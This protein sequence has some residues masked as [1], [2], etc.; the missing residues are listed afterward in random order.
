MLAVGAL[1]LALVIVFAWQSGIGQHS[2]TYV[3]VDLHSLVVD[4]ANPSHLFVGG[5]QG[6]ARSDDAGHSWHPLRSLDDADAMGWAFT[7][8]ATW[9]SGHPGVH[10]SA[11]GGLHF[12]GHNEGLPATDVH[13][14]G[15]NDR[16]LYAGSPVVGVMV[17]TDGAAH[18]DIRTRDTGQAFFGHILVDPA[19]PDHAVAADARAGAVETTDG[20]RHWK[21]LGGVNGADWVSW[22][23]DQ[24]SHLVVTGDGQAAAS[25]DGGRTWQAL[26]VPDG[27]SIVEAAPT[28]ASVLYAAAHRGTHARIWV[29]RDGGAHWRTP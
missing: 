9:Q 21:V 4:P 26:T 13:A 12:S 6:V 7:S 14:F 23:G 28:D 27:V 10:R 18:W 25:V 24:P 2:G 1:V 15:G 5:H 17:S 29:S 3:G 22:A 8:A 19:D 16:I 20:G 11:D